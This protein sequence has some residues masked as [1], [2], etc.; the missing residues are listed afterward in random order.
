MSDLIEVCAR[1]HRHKVLPDAAPGK[2]IQTR[3]LIVLHSVCGIF[4]LDGE[5]RQHLGKPIQTRG[6]I[7]LHSVCGIFTLTV[8]I[9]GTSANQFKHEV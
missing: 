6:L 1:H 2:P 4:T 8:K 9:G 5:D 3:G 7:V